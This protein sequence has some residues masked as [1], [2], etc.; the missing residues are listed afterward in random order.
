MLHSKKQCWRS[1]WYNHLIKFNHL[2]EWNFSF[3]VNSLPIVALCGDKG[4]GST[5]AQLVV[6]ARRHQAINQM[7]IV[8][9]YLVSIRGQLLWLYTWYADKNIITWN[10]ISENCYVTM[11]TISDGQTWKHQFAYVQGTIP[12]YKQSNIEVYHRLKSELAHTELKRI[13]QTE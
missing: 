5:V 9:G 13:F 8:L 7:N 11:L 4:I 10:Q 1:I 6:L 3:R 2:P 12:P